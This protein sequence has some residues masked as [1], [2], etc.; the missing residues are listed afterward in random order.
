MYFVYRYSL[1]HDIRQ[2]ACFAASGFDGFSGFN[3]FSGC[4]D[5]ELALEHAG[6][7]NKWPKISVKGQC[8]GQIYCDMP[9]YPLG[10]IL[11]I[12]LSAGSAIIATKQP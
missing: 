1:H 12:P 6:S 5:K 11:Q 3:R 8:S 9:I 4:H 10:G 2:Y 7:L